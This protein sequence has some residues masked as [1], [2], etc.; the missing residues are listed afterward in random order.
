[1][2]DLKVDDDRLEDSLGTMRGL[3]H[4]F[5][6]VEKRNDETRDAWGHDGVRS[7][8]EEFSGNMDYNSRKLSE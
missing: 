1:M 8:M 3:K 6:D 7:A 2:S 5:D 4:A